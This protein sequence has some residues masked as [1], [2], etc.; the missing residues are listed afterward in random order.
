[1]SASF[2]VLLDLALL[3]LLGLLAVVVLKMR[4]GPGKRRFARAARRTDEVA[5][6]TVPTRYMEE[7]T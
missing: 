2:A 5:A 6:S 4:N 3:G 1:M 7:P